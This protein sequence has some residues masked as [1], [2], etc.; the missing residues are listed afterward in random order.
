MN[1]NKR[2]MNDY[3]R[4][5]QSMTIDKWF[6]SGYF[7]AHEDVP[8]KIAQLLLYASEL[9]FKDEELVSKLSVLVKLSMQNM[10]GHIGQFKKLLETFQK[11][12]EAK[13]LPV[14]LEPVWNILKDLYF[15]YTI[16]IN[17]KAKNEELMKLLLAEVESNKKA[18]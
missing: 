7:Q 4:R 14:E 15:D 11:Q 3:A 6:S 2:P 12:Y 16:P 9:S 1:N 8:V 18:K 17:T 13:A 5:L 10:S